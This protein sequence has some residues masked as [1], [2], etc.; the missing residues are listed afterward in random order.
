MRHPAKDEIERVLSRAASPP[1]ASDVLGHILSC[2]VCLG[3][4]E[5]VLKDNVQASTG[6]GDLLRQ[7]LEFEQG[8]V[9]ESFLADAYWM[10]MRSLSVKV[11]KDRI[12]TASVC[13]TAVFARLL[14]EGLAH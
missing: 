11:Q 10:E 9:V 3:T 7:Y 8:N 6:A 2:A 14:L 5:R 4:A 13:K 1:E 12:A